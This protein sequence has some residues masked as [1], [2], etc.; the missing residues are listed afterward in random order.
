MYTII[1]TCIDIIRS[2]RPI[3]GIVV[4]DYYVFALLG[5]QIFQ[6]T[7]TLETFKNET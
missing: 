3:L 1:G 2:L 4:V 5:Q 7:I 6:K